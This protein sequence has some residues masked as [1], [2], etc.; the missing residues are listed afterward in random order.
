VTV[1][2]GEIKRLKPDGK[3]VAIALMRSDLANATIDVLAEDQPDAVV[4]DHGTYLLVSAD[5][6]IMVR[7]DRVSDE[8]GATV[9]L[10]QWL[11]IMST[12]IGRAAPGA[13]Y[14]R[15]TSQMLDLELPS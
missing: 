2:A 7:M 5:D 13:D 1:A 15:V 10:G 8:M 3:K 4:T 12:F 11:V 14:M 6:E 9:T